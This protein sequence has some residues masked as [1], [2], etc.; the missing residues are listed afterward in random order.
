MKLRNYCLKILFLF[1]LPHSF[2]SILEAQIVN[3]YNLVE[4]EDF[5]G[6]NGIQVVGNSN[7]AG[8]AYID[9]GDFI[10]FD[11]VGFANGPISGGILASSA[12]NGGLI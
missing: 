3:P 12:T 9:N 7:R 11:N 6:Q 4:S 1:L 8:V 10:R 2:V 5:D